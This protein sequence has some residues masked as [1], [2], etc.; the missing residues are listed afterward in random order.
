MQDRVAE[1]GRLAIKHNLIQYAE[2]ACNVVARARQGSLRARIWTDYTRAELLLKKPSQEIDPKTGMR[3]NTLQR[4]R[5]DFERRAEA[6]KILDRAMIANK[7][8]ADADIIIEGCTLIWNTGIP[9]LKGS[10]RMH[11]YKPFQAATAALEKIEAQE[12]SLRVC[13]Y[14]EL[15]KY[16]IDQDFLSKAT[17]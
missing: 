15:A 5:E 11:I 3:L 9:L 14:L 13:L 7:R 12:N 10:T 2:G 4:Q 1:C 8:L 17:V 16:E 6:L